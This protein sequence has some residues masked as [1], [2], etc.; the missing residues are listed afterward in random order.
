M[1]ELDGKLFATM[2]DNDSAYANPFVYNSHNQWRSLTLLPCINFSLVT[3]PDHIKLLAIGGAINNNGIVVVSNRV[4]QWDEGNKKWTTPYPNMPTARYCC[5]SI[6][7]ESKVIVAGGITC[8][9][10]YTL[11]RA[12]EVLCINN[13]HSYWSVV[14]QL[15]FALYEAIPLILSNTLY[16]A[17]GYSAY[18]RSRS[19]SVLTASIPELLQSSNR[20]VSGRQVWV[21]LRDMPYSSYSINHYDGHLIAF[22]GGIRIELPDKEKPVYEAVPQIH[23]YNPYINTWDC[24]GEIPHGYL[25]G[26]SGH[27]KP[28]EILFIGGITVAP[29]F[30]NDDHVLTT[31]STLTISR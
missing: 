31:C 19:Y 18:G 25:L 17:Q 7:L 1:A 2:Q 28:N 8:S 10:P 13:H 12:V 30:I 23:I 24:V 27:V 11:T 15:P 26:R 4:F 6:S 22:S 16:L 14:E 3:A 29:T 5:S 9:H 21:K 20:S